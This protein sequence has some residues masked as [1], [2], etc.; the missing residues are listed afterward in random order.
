MQRVAEAERASMFVARRGCPRRHVSHFLAVG[1]QDS[2]GPLASSRF[3]NSAFMSRLGVASG[4]AVVFTSRW[5][6]L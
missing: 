2:R 4:D 5:K 3:E 6:T 1:A